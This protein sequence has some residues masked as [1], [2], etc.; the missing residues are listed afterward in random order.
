DVTK[1]KVLFSSN[2]RD[3]K[4]KA[5]IQALYERQKSEIDAPLIQSTLAQPITTTIP[6]TIEKKLI[7]SYQ[8]RLFDLS[9]DDDDEKSLSSDDEDLPVDSNDYSDVNL[10]VNI[11]NI[12]FLVNS[13]KCPKCDVHG[14]YDFKVTKRLGLS[15][16]NL[17]YVFVWKYYTLYY[18]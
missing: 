17:I 7:S 3:R 1:K 4:N 5:K 15:Y 11:Q 18:W 8:R 2:R 9:T 12:L 14:Q 10:I 16:L 13:M 6:S